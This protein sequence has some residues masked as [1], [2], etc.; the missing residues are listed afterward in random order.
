[1]DRMRYKTKPLRFF[2]DVAVYQCPNCHIRI[3]VEIPKEV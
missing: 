2:K 3:I 1:M